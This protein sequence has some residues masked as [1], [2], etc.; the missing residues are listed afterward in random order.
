MALP[1]T[2]P[3]NIVCWLVGGYFGTPPSVYSIAYD[4]DNLLSEIQMHHYENPRAVQQGVKILGITQAGPD[5]V[6]VVEDY[7]RVHHQESDDG[8]NFAVYVCK[9]DEEVW[10]DWKKNL[11]VKLAL[12]KH[13]MGYDLSKHQLDPTKMK[14]Q[15]RHITI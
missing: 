9:T 5:D 4:A 10:A 11:A 7:K 2:K 3:T 15:Q 13:R 12:F 6:L 14:G 1:D 8:P